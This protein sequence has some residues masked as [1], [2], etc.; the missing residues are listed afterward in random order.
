MF[1]NLRDDAVPSFY[2]EDDTILPEEY[3]KKPVSK[4]P[5]RKTNG[6]FLG[7]TSMQRFIIV[8]MLLVAVCTLGS[9]CLLLTGKIG[10]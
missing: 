4:A 2:E 8:A 10:L 3:E 6:K 9:M 5:K 1:D 7:M